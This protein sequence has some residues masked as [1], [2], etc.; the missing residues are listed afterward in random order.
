MRFKIFPAP[1]FGSGSS[2]GSEC[3]RSRQ[4]ITSDVSATV[5][6]EFFFSDGCAR[7]RH[8]LGVY[9]FTELVMRDTEDGGFGH[10]LVKVDGVLDFGSVD[11]LL[12]LR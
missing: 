10:A 9:G 8:D 4:L 11:V 5:L 6:D 12:P 2:A 1:D 3:H 7:L